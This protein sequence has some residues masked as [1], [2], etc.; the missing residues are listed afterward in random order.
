MVDILKFYIAGIF[1]YKEIEFTI[2]Q[3]AHRLF[4]VLSVTSKLLHFLSTFTLRLQQVNQLKGPSP[5]S[6]SVQY[7]TEC[8]YDFAI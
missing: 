5:P 3:L 2:V 8:H 4:P 1:I 7:T 6:P